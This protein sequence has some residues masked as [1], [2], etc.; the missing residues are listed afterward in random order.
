MAGYIPNCGEMEALIDLLI[1]QALKIGLYKAHI[2]PDGNTVFSSITPLTLDANGYQHKDL[3]NGVVLDV[4]TANK[5]FVSINTAGK[6]EAKYH[7]ADVEWTFTQADV[8]KG[9]TVY[10]AFMWALLLA[11]NTGT[12]EIKVGDTVTGA[13]SGATAVVTSVRLHSGT[14]GGGNAAGR[15]CVM[16]KTGTFQANENLQVSAVTK[17]KAEGDT[18]SMLMSVN[19]ATTAQKVETLGQKIKCDIRFTMATGV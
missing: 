10:G 14:W 2:T 17:A 18:T 1:S 5:W 13:T 11:F 8:D 3:A 12:G 19:P 7:N 16:S 6:A 9:E 15:L 4:A